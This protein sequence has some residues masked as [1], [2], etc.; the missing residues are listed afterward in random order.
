[1]KM[2]CRRR[3]PH[4][5]PPLVRSLAIALAAYVLY[6]IPAE[7]TSLPSI[8]GTLEQARPPQADMGSPRV[9]ASLPDVVPLVVIHIPLAR[10]S[11]AESLVQSQIDRLGSFLRNPVVQ[12]R[13]ARSLP[14]GRS[15]SFA[16]W[17]VPA[18]LAKGV[19]CL[20]TRSAFHPLTSPRLTSSR[21]SV[22][23]AASLFA[24]QTAASPV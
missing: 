12:P 2:H 20:P 24:A 23:I 3:E 17:S 15:S 16:W 18:L 22:S 8:A 7:G 13:H 9:T 5:V 14:N 6:C 10:Y 4:S 1:M 19:P 11:R 21:T